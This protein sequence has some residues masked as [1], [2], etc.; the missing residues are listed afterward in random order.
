MSHC[1][2][3][4]KQ[5]VYATC[6]FPPDICP[7]CYKSNFTLIEIQLSKEDLTKQYKEIIESCRQDIKKYET[8]IKES[9]ELIEHYNK[10][11]VPDDYLQCNCCKKYFD[12]NSIW[13]NKDE[14]HHLCFDCY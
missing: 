7:K 5:F 6:N 4:K 10:L 3:C 2:M 8:K 14:V 1:T 12:K 11:L 9:L 13:V